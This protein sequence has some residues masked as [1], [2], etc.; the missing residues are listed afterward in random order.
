MKNMYIVLTAIILFSVEIADSAGIASSAV[1]YGFIKLPQT[2][3]LTVDNVE[4]YVAGREH[5]IGKPDFIEWVPE[6][7]L[8]NFGLDTWN[9]EYHYNVVVM[10]GEDVIAVV[11]YDE[12]VGF[13]FLTYDGTDALV[14]FADIRSFTS[15]QIYQSVQLV[16]CGK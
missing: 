7:A 12:T 16:E 2:A 1:F 13:G 11:N 4:I 6:L 5:I 9:I 14:Q 15:C 8:W 10:K 3:N